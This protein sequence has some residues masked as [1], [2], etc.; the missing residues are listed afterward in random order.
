M[1]L[2]VEIV[3]YFVSVLSL[4]FRITSPLIFLGWERIQV[5]AFPSGNANDPVKVPPEVINNPMSCLPFGVPLSGLGG[6]ETNTGANC[7]CSGNAAVCVSST[8]ALLAQHRSAGA[9]L[10][11]R[12]MGTDGQCQ[13]MLKN[14][15]M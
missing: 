4:Y 7:F 10:G 13:H 5:P 6:R 11:Q 9:R 2:G 12:Q 8:V 1:F 3:L 15:K 14:V